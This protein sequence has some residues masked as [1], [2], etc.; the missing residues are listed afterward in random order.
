MKRKVINKFLKNYKIPFSR[1]LLILFYVLINFIKIH[2]QNNSYLNY[3]FQA[4]DNSQID[5]SKLGNK[6]MIIVPFD[7]S[8]PNRQQLLQLDSLF[9][10]NKSLLNVIAI[11]S[12]DFGNALNEGRLK[13]LLYDTLNLSILIAKISSVKKISGAN[14]QPI[15]QWL[16]D[17]NLNGHFDIDISNPG[18]IFIISENGKLFARISSTIDINYIKKIINKKVD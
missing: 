13:K 10:K 6:K 4:L 16:T 9:R 1:I 7:A 12:L 14:Q 2:A 15:M 3:K 5:I 8:N 18:E 11:P 17:K